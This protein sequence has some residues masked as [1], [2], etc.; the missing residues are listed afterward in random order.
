[1][2]DNEIIKALECCSKKICKQCP[3]F[4]EDIECSEKLINLTLDYIARQK[5]EIK[6]L[7]S[8]NQAKLDTIHGLQVEIDYLRADLKRGCAERR[9][10]HT[11]I[12]NFTKVESILDFSE[13]LK[14]KAVGLKLVNRDYRFVSVKEIDGLVIKMSGESNGR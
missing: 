4:S 9:D 11:C 6:R 8:I 3:N 13:R 14:Q 7:Q 12:N 10:A 2:N 1:M 5:S